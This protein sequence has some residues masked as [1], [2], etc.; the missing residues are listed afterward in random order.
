MRPRRNDTCVLPID[1]PRSVVT[2]LEILARIAGVL[3]VTSTLWSAMLTVV[4]PRSE[5]PRITRFHFRLMGWISKAA[6]GKMS[7]S[8]QRYL[9]DS[10]LAPFGL[11]SLAF[12]WAFHIIIGFGFI[13]WGQ[14]VRSLANAFLLSGSSLTTLG[15]RDADTTVT[16]V[17]VVIEGL[18]GLG[19]V[20]LMISYLPTVYNAYLERE[21]AV[22]RLEVRAGRPS[23][24]L[25]FL[26][27]SHRIGWLGEMG[28]V[29]TNWENW[30][31]QIEETHSTHTSLSFFRSA[32]HLS[33]IHI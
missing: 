20:G 4:V 8:E 33:L 30:F 27:R 31:L 14:G 22:A 1:Y 10:R 18:I 2:A 16:L 24:P 19:L 29:W 26:V 25:T 28:P 17:I 11:V 9:F 15:I 23:H 12:V 3:I 32:Q 7:S 21:V 13:Y 5:R 6:H